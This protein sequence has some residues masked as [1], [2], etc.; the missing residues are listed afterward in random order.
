MVPA[1]AAGIAVS[2]AG[3]AGFAPG[4]WQGHWRLLVDQDF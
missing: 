3:R 4:L 2:V 1:L